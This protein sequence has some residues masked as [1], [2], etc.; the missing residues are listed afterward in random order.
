M[1]CGNI[2]QSAQNHRPCPIAEQLLSV[3]GVAIRY[4]RAFILLFRCQIVTVYIAFP[5]RIKATCRVT[6]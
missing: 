5:E 2:F 6:K 1:Q 4:S 3:S